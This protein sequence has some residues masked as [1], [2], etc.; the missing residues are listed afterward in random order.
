M[1]KVTHKMAEKGKVAA[2]KTATKVAPRS[3]AAAKP[4][5]FLAKVP[6]EYV[7]WC[8]DGQVFRDINDLL[9]G[10]EVMSDETFDYHVNDEKN[11]FSC[12][13][14]DIVGDG[15]LAQEV[16]KTRTRHQAK[17]VTQQ[18]YYDLTRQEG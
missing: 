3:V 7:F 18:R 13:I 5:K 9:N 8:H 17:K 15:D 10:F 16:K 14:L 4:E 6:E 2:P 1:A 11:D 12:W